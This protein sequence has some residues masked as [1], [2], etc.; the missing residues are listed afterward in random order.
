MKNLV[1]AAMLAASAMPAIAYAQSEDARKFGAR[2]FIQQ[3]SLSPDGTQ[4]AMLQPVSGRGDALMVANLETGESKMVLNSSGDPDQITSCRWASTTRLVCNIYMIGKLDKKLAFTRMVSLNADGSDLKLLS[5]RDSATALDIIQSGGDII[6]WG[7]DGSN[8]SVLMTREFVPE[9]STGSHVANAREGLAV[10]LV[11][12][13]T[14]KRK[15]V[16][17]PRGGAN[18]Y[19]SD[20]HGNVRIIGF[21]QARNEGM[22]TGNYSY[23]YRTAGDRDWKKL[24]D[25][26]SDGGGGYSGFNPYAVDRDANVVYG[27]DDKDGRSALYSIALDGSLTR[28]L[29][30]AHPEVDVD[31]LVRIGRQRRV[32]GVSYATDKR[33]T[34]FFDP[35]LQKLRNALGRA[36]PGKPLV[37]FIDASADEK[38]LLLF[39][40]GDTDPGTY[41]LYDKTSKQLGEV[42]PLRPPLAETKLASVKPV[43]FPAADGTQIPGYL[44][45]PVGSDGK[46]LPAIVMPHGG[47]GSRDEWGF[48]WLAQFYAA[49]GFAVLQ[50]NFRGS[51][52]YGDGWF[53]KNGFQSW[54]TAIGDVNDGGRWLEKQGIAAPGKL[55]IVGWSYGGYAALQSPALDPDLF[56]AIVA[57]AP[58]TDLE[59]LRNEAQGFTSYNIVS[60]FIGS[61]PHVKEGSPAQNVQKIKAPVLM[62]HGDQ[63]LNVGIGESRMMAS[64][65]RGA[66]K[67]VELVE[68]KGLDH[69]LDDDKARTQMLDKSDAF[70]RAALGLAAK[71]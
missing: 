27:F 33:T 10:E 30:F 1:R 8:G 2:E 60:K 44:T 12:A 69:Q 14:L 4:V 62:F 66:G 58:V 53:Q 51:T 57:I 67:P 3:I 20:G 6:D 13:T 26:V 21:A 42:M 28:K 45:L 34:E 35:E 31:G 40:G 15:L 56:K 64:R 39:A 16:E 71:P 17:S 52:G 11:D 47:P 29:V 46:N 7:P 50:P 19:I 25:L 5:Q 48:D 22:L 63:D 61:G 54:R 55:A 24:G 65:L 49:R 68:F 37:T 59:T 38:K 36:L 43:T 9:Y 23:Q 32:V 18:E 70:L 41:Y